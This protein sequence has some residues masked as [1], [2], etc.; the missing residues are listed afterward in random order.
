MPCSWQ[1][2]KKAFA[3]ANSVRWSGPV[4]QV[5]NQ[6]WR[7]N[8]FSMALVSYGLGDVVAIIPQAWI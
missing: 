8:P 5:R 4:F 7:R 6:T 3:M 1:K 2:E